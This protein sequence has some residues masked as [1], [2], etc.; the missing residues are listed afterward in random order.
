VKEFDI[1]KV[2][3]KEF[4]KKELNKIEKELKIWQ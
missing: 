2:K 4:Y 1:L 3:V